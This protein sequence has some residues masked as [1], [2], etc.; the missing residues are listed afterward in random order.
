VSAKGGG[1]QRVEA[2]AASRT[3]ASSAAVTLTPQFRAIAA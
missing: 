3:P 1:D 2:S